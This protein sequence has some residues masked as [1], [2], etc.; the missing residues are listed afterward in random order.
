[1]CLLLCLLITGCNKDEKYKPEL[2]DVIPI[3]LQSKVFDILTTDVNDYDK[4]YAFLSNTDQTVTLNISNLQGPTGGVNSALRTEVKTNNGRLIELDDVALN[5]TVWADIELVT[6]ETLI[7]TLSTYGTFRDDFYE[8]EIEIL[9]NTDNGL[10]VNEDTFEP[11]DT[12]NIATNI[13][14]NSKISTELLIG[15]L[16]QSDVFK[17]DLQAGITY[18]LLVTNS[19]GPSSSTIGGLRFLLTDANNNPV[20]AD[21]DMKQAM[22]SNLQFTPRSSGFHYLRISSPPS[23]IYQNEYYSYEFAIWEPRALWDNPFSGDDFEP[24]ETNALAYEIDVSQ[25][26]NSQL[27]QGADDYLDSYALEIFPGTKYKISITASDG[28]N[29]SALSNLRFMVTD[30]SGGFFF[31]PEQSIY[32]SQTKTIELTTNIEQ[33]AIIKLYYVPTSGHELDFHAYSMVAEVI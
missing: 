14:L 3:E 30:D 1:M 24:N 13:N 26:L 21:F 16:D 25:I 33:V 9:P 8:F 6:G 22:S 7:I 10:I 19:Q 29:R 12:N 2:N 11:N 20:I 31:A 32:V 18:S 27:T 4:T 23:T 15:S 28:P 17:V 5:N